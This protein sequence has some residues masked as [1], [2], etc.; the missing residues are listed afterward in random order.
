MAKTVLKS[1]TLITSA[2][3]MSHGIKVPAG[4]MVFV[5]GQ[6][7]RNAQG[8]LVGKGDIFAQ[9]RQTLENL[10]SVLEAGGAT[11]DDV[12]KVTVVGTNGVEHY[13]QIHAARAEYF[14]SDYPASTMVEVSSLVDPDM[15]IEIEAIAVV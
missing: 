5:S 7:A 6:V 3:I 12:V 15:L 8:E 10:K 2:G 9:T 4:N 14:K 1:P 11:M 13:T